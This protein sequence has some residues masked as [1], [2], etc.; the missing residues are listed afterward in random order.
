MAL[1]F[2]YDQDEQGKVLINTDQI[3][4]AKALED[5]QGKVVGSRIVMSDS[6]NTTIHATE[7][8]EQIYNSSRQ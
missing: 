5:K 2:V 6:N 7:T 3:V 4:F 8:M 1:I